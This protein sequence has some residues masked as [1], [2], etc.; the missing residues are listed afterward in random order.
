MCYRGGTSAAHCFLLGAERGFC[1][2]ARAATFALLRHAA[3]TA[4]AGQRWRHAMPRARGHFVCIAHYF[5]V[6]AHAST[7]HTWVRDNFA[8]H[9]L[10]QHATPRGW[11][12]KQRPFWFS[13]LIPLFSTPM[14]S[15]FLYSYFAFCNHHSSLLLREGTCFWRSSRNQTGSVSVSTRKNVTLIRT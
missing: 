1:A 11:V 8:E 14:F 12:N 2:S 5:Y 13:T 7:V 6:Y 3:Y 9:E 4:G 10:N 15:G